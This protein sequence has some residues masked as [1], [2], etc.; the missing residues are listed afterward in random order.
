[1]SFVGP[2]TRVEDP[3]LHY[4]ARSEARWVGWY[5]VSEI[6]EESGNG[7]ADEGGG[8]FLR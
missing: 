5:F 2:L 4:P 3:T 1:M 6:E 8:A 7:G